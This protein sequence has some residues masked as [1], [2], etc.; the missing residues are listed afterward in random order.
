MISTI[1]VFSISTKLGY[2][3]DFLCKFSVINYLITYILLLVE[4]SR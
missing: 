4:V 2:S 1:N 3:E